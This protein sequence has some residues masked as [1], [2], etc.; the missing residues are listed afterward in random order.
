MSFGGADGIPV[1]WKLQIQGAEDVKKKLA[2][3]NDQFSRGETSAIDAAKGYREAHKEMRTLNTVQTANKEIFLASHPALLAYTRAMSTFSSAANTALSITNAINLATIVAQGTDQAVLDDKQKLAQAQIDYASTMR[4]FPN[5]LGRIADAYSKVQLAEN[6]LA[7]DQRKAAIQMV[8]NWITVASSVVL[9]GGQIGQLIA[10]KD[11]IAANISQ[12]FK[13]PTVAA[14]GL[15]TGVVAV[16]IAALA[17]ASVIGDQVNPAFTKFRKDLETE[18]GNNWITDYILAPLLAIPVAFDQAT[19][20][21][22]QSWDDFVKDATTNWINFANWVITGVNDINT[23]LRSLNIPG[24]GGANVPLIKTLAEQKQ[25]AAAD[26]T[27]QF[28]LTGKMPGVTTSS[29]SRDPVAEM[30]DKLAQQIAQTKKN[31]ESML[32]NN[33]SLD[34]NSQV[35]KDGVDTSTK[36]TNTLSETNPILDNVF[37][38]SDS[39]TTAI[40]ALTPSVMAQSK[41]MQDSITQ[42]TGAA[43]LMKD[44][45]QTGIS[46]QTTSLADLQDKLAQA[47]KT[48]DAA[49]SA[50]AAEINANGSPL[51]ASDFPDIISAMHNVQDIQ[52]QID[53]T[54]AQVAALQSKSQVLDNAT[55]GLLPILSAMGLSPDT[56]IGSVISGALGGAAGIGGAGIT[57]DQLAEFVNTHDY[58]VFTKAAIGD[59]FPNGSTGGHGNGPTDQQQIDAL[60]N[61]LAKDLGVDLASHPY[62]VQQAH[63]TLLKGKVIKSATGFSG[64]VSSP[65]MF[66]A[67][68]AGLEN[69]N[70]RP[71]GRSSSNGQGTTNIFIQP[72]GSILAQRDLFKMFDDY[73]KG[74]LKSNGF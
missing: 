45:V 52:S 29:T 55:S 59:S 34:S 66:M 74:R 7:I 56:G 35:I 6:Q 14:A 23:A 42:Q 24:I 57:A 17:L 67:G 73:F 44:A 63:D 30:N 53:Q 31:L 39:L 54:K 25:G 43:N 49:S 72:A 50:H 4:D 18:F 8:Q 11:N 19:G 60:A 68:E 36:L 10:Q 2:D 37:R 64:M 61:S 21:S 22:A 26:A 62:L 38:S 27:N 65:T 28:L 70:I 15:A 20:G 1:I 32:L 51:T 41:I 5:D 58:G 3:I 47:Q 40:N 33:T 46:T 9:V 71:L 69:V 48:L 12:M 16:A 13:N